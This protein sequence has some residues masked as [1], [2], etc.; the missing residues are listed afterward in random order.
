LNRKRERRK[1]V[2]KKDFAEDESTGKW[3]TGGPFGP[4]R[5]AKSFQIR[6]KAGTNIRNRKKSPGEVK[7]GWTKEKTPGQQ[8]RSKRGK[9]AK[10]RARRGKKKRPKWKCQKGKKNQG[11]EKN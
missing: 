5:R 7:K 10:I 2:E 11:R 4:G 9:V 3:P 1:K 8:G 6:S